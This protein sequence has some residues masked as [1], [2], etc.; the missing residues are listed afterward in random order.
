MALTFFKID[1]GLSLSTIDL[2][3]AGYMVGDTVHVIPA[4]SWSYVL[5]AD[6]I[7]KATRY[8]YDNV[9]HSQHDV[10][11]LTASGGT[12]VHILTDDSFHED[13]FDADGDYGVY[14]GHPDVNDSPDPTGKVTFPV[15]GLVH[16]VSSSPVSRLDA[17]EAV[18]DLSID[19][20]GGG[21]SS[22]AGQSSKLII[23]AIPLEILSG[24]GNDS[25][26]ASLGSSRVDG[27][28]GEDT[29]F[30]QN[31]LSDVSILEVSDGFAKLSSMVGETEFKNAEHIAFL[32]GVIHIG[33][34][35]LDLVRYDQA[36]AGVVASLDLPSANEGRASGDMY[37]SIEGLVG[38]AFDD[39]LQGDAGDNH[40]LGGG[41]SDLLFGHGGDDTLQGGDGND[42]LCGGIGADVL[43]GGEGSDTYYA[44]EADA[45]ADTGTSGTD[46]VIVTYAE[47]TAASNTYYLPESIENLVLGGNVAIGAGNS[48]ANYMQG[49]ELV[50]AL[51]GGDGADTLVGLGGQDWL[52][53]DAGADFI[54]GGTED[55]VIGGGADADW[56]LGEDGNDAIWG[57]DGNDVISGASGSDYIIGGTGYDLLYGGE[58]NDVFVVARVDQED[59][60]FGEAGA[61]TVYFADRASAELSSIAQTENGYTTISFTDGHFSSVTGIEW[62]Q[63]TD[64]GWA[65]SS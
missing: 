59:I 31:K 58:G 11:T 41:G 22:A 35:G 49:N 50:N 4:G 10:I 62:I 30:I 44:D 36:A 12:E 5:D 28:G 42:H 14:I 38:S 57:D 33:G 17:S 54:Y 3:A 8:I 53:G 26:F 24:Q 61:D 21:I 25:I 15:D 18:V 19:A 2:S 6:E 1:P 45:L 16:L 29:V 32:D 51:Y 52:Q 20:T 48:S 9:I 34:S 65:I 43:D 56:L 7:S 27:G 47:G 23:D 55:D 40:L 64:A 46:T 13:N 60:I 37:F 63:F 39:N